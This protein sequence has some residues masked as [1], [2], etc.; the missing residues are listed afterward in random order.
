MSQPKISG[1]RMPTP[2]VKTTSVSHSPFWKGRPT[3]VTGAGGFL[4]RWLVHRLVDAGADVVC[5]VRD[6]DRLTKPPS[7]E[8]VSRVRIVR[9]D[10]RDYDS[11][12]RI[13]HDSSV[14]TVIHL[15][16]QAIVGIAMRD[17]MHTLETNV[18]GS[19]RILEACRKTPS[20]K[21]V[22]VASSDKAYAPNRPLP[23]DEATPLEGRY[24]YEVSKSCADL[25]AQMY[26]IT[27]GVPLCI[28]RCGNFFGGG[29]INF[30]RVVPG[31]IR[32]VLQGERPLI[33]SDGLYVRDYLYIEDAVEA[34]M[35]LA[36]QLAARPELAGQAFNFSN[37]V[38]LT[39]IDLVREIL[40]LMG[41]DLEPSVMNSASNEVRETYL[42]AERARRELGWSPRFSVEEGLERAIAWYRDFVS[43]Y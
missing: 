6:P 18:A 40:H 43:K 37:E 31:T 8:T 28:A 10:L 12:V 38:R 16:A 23:F 35:L 34:H 19:W 42:T 1:V 5:V 14:D 22:V 29:D 13:L 15:A 32:S 11:V 4:G 3:L 17:P 26:G 9:N 21:Q 30:N 41:S 25:V 20:V 2:V 27:F 7:M 24:P 36:E 33:R 39:V